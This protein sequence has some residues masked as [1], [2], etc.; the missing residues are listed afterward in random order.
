MV[1]YSQHAN[2]KELISLEKRITKSI[3]TS[4]KSFN[5]LCQQDFSCEADGLKAIKRWEN[6]QGFA[7][8][9]SFS[10]EKITKHKSRGRPALNAEGTISYQVNGTIICSSENRKNAEKNLGIFIL[11]TNDCS[12]HLDMQA[13]L[14]HYKSQQK[15]E[16]GFRFL[17]SPDFLVSSLFL[18]KPERIE[19]LLMVMTCCLMVYAAL[20]HLIRTSLKKTGTFFPDMKKKPCQNPTARWVFQCFQGIHVLDITQNNMN[21]IVVINLKERHQIIL[22]AIGKPF[23]KIYS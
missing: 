8:L 18:K 3:E 14:D 15:V 22:N 9:E 5:K 13:M 12:E 17:K 21:Q 20:E 10:I 2:K 19:A 6:E 7:T 1:V 11:A 23:M 4:Q 16:G